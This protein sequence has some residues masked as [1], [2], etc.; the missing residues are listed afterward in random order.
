[1]VDLKPGDTV[2]VY[3]GVPGFSA[4]LPWSE[5]SPY[6]DG[7]YGKVISVKETVND[8]PPNYIKIC[9][10]GTDQIFI[11]HRKQ[12]RKI[13]TP[14]SNIKSV[15]VRNE[16]NYSEEDISLAFFRISNPKTLQKLIASLRGVD[17]SELYK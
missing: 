2:K 9:M 15:L 13:S 14:D 16:K 8:L 11:F 6:Y 1:M 17:E 12:L 4:P 7:D 3:G 5:G 10:A